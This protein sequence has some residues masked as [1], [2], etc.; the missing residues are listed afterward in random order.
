MGVFLYAR[1]IGFLELLKEI[2][3]TSVGYSHDSAAL[4]IGKFGTGLKT[5]EADSRKAFAKGSHN[6]TGEYVGKYTV[7]LFAP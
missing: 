5:K 6:M 2:V 4:W 3:V 7:V 1:F